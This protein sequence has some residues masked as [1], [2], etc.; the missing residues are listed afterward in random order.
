ML[1]F[2]IS[3]QAISGQETLEPDAVTPGPLI[4]YVSPQGYRTVAQP[5]FSERFQEVFDAE[6]AP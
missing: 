1:G 5:W 6:V 4:Y 3:E 2:A